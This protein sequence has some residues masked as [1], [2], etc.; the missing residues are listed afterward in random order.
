MKKLVSLLLIASSLAASAQ[1]F[2][3]DG[4]VGY[5]VDSEEAYLAV[6]GGTV[7]KSNT[8]IQ[9]SL[10]LEIAFTEEQDSGAKGQILPVTLNYRAEFPGT[11]K[12]V[13]FVGAGAGVARVKFDG[14]GYSDSDYVFAAQAFAGLGY[15]ASE[16]VSLNVAARYI[17]LGDVELFGVEAELGDDVSVEV[18]V[19]IRF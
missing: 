19:S 13:P 9:H 15:K 5:L 17:W 1:A 2:Y 18:G 14:F 6:R 4:S 12:L 8:S 16:T 10:E 7:V 3:L 11:G